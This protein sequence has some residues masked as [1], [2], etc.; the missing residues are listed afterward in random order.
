MAWK[1]LEV[2]AGVPI[3]PFWQLFLAPKLPLLFQKFWWC[4]SAVAW[5]CAEWV[6][7]GIPA[8]N[9][10]RNPQKTGSMVLSYSI[11]GY[12]CWWTFFMGNV[13]INQCIAWSKN[14]QTNLGQNGEIFLARWAQ[15]PPNAWWFWSTKMSPWFGHNTP[16]GYIWK[17]LEVSYLMILFGTKPMGFFKN[18]LVAE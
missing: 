2:A 3:I 10:L 18:F 17:L 4:W 12:S 16:S 13:R 7:P 8:K 6:V 9:A 15:S 14:G 1:L 5:R 11:H